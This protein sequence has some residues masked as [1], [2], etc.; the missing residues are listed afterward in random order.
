MC[1]VCGYEDGTTK[2]L[3]YWQAEW[4]KRFVTTWWHIINRRAYWKW[5][6]K[7][8]IAYRTKKVMQS[9][10]DIDEGLRM[11]LDEILKKKD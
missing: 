9:I 4:F 3:L 10:L 5:C 6:E 8:R 2:H 7:N 11:D 1:G